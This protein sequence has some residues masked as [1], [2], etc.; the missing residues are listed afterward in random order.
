[1]ASELA[2]HKMEQTKW[3]KQLTDLA[4]KTGNTYYESLGLEAMGKRIYSE[5]NRQQGI[6]YVKEALDLIETTDREDADHLAHSY[7]L[8]LNGLYAGGV[9]SLRCAEVPAGGL[10][11]LYEHWSAGGLS[12]G[13]SGR[14]S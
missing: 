10:A 4:K 1:M 8:I 11:T 6:Q 5:G 9:V 2:D 3:M 13:K 12:K 14:G 7:M